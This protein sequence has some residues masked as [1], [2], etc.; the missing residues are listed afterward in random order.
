MVVSSLT[1]VIKCLPEFL[2]NS[3]WKPS[4]AL[5]FKFE[6]LIIFYN[7][8][9]TFRTELKDSF[10]AEISSRVISSRVGYNNMDFLMQRAWEESKQRGLPGFV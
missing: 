2:Y 5:K 9:L 1:S 10:V 6:V 4:P 7:S 8:Y 3:K